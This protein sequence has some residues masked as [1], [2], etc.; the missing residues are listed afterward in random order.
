MQWAAIDA[1]DCDVAIVGG[2][3]RLAEDGAVWLDIEEE[4]GRRRV[5]FFVVAEACVEVAGDVA[6]CGDLHRR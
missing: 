1:C 3:W 6:A 2:R 4:T 5:R